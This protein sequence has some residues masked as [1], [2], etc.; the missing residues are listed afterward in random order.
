MIDTTRKMFRFKL[1]HDKG[2]ENIVIPAIDEESAIWMIRALEDCPPEAIEK[3]PNIGNDSV[4]VPDLSLPPNSY[5][6]Y[7]TYAI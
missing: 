5:N 7:K 1:H 4:H 6:K 3:L 2:T